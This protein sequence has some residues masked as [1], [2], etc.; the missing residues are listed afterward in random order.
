MSESEMIEDI[1]RS[2]RNVA[3][4]GLSMDSAKDSH[5][6]ALYLKH[7]G[8]RITPVNPFAGETLNEISYGSLLDIP[9]E[10]VRGWR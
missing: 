3:V 2:Y 9:E 4:L 10:L 8:Y 6:V 7:H 1:L 5:E